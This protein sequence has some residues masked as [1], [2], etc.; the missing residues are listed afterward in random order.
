MR[1]SELHGLSGNCA[2][3]GNCGGRAPAAV[4]AAAAG[5]EPGRG[6]RQGLLHLEPIPPRK[7][8][9][10]KERQRPT[11]LDEG[12]SPFLAPAAAD[13]HQRGPLGMTQLRRPSNENEGMP[14][15]PTLSRRYSEEPPPLPVILGR[16]PSNED[17]AKSAIS[18][19]TPSSTI[20]M[21]RSNGPPTPELA[22]HPFHAWCDAGAG[23][24]AMKE[25][26]ATSTKSPCRAPAARR[27][28]DPAVEASCPKQS[29]GALAQGSACASGRAA[30]G[31]RR[32]REVLFEEGQPH[33]DDAVLA[34]VVLGPESAPSRA[35]HAL[36]TE[37]AAESPPPPPE[38]VMCR[39]TTSDPVALGAISEQT[40]SP[41]AEAPPPVNIAKA[42]RTLSNPECFR[43]NHR[44]SHHDKPRRSAHRHR[45]WHEELASPLSV[46][47]S[48]AAS[49]ETG[50][51][52]SIAHRH[53][54][55]PP[56]S[57]SSGSS[58][59]GDISG[60]HWKRGP[61]IGAGSYG[62]VFTALSEHGKIFAVKQAVLDDNESDRMFRCRLQEE[63][64]ICKTLRHP[65]IVSYLGH[66]YINNAL[67]I[68]LEYVPGGSM[69]SILKEFGPLDDKP[70]RLASRGLLEGL[71]HL[72]S[73]SPP[74]VHRDI[75]GANVLVDLNFR[76][77]LADFGCSKRGDDT[78]SLR[79]VGS[80][81]WMAPEVILQQDGHGRKADV[82]SLGCTIIEMS[83]AQKP[84]G[85][86]AFDN[87]ACALRHIAM[88]DATPPVPEKL[89]ENLMD[90]VAQCTRREPKSRPSARQAVQ[91]EAL[92]GTSPKRARRP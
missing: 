24:T 67:Y 92:E 52:P 34:D 56:A 25:A 73:R 28:V 88:S 62:C 5:A 6:H 35:P 36:R 44:S 68:Y 57:T 61:K 75:K 49:V 81:P 85:D 27:A 17:C 4:S 90:L 58:D 69:A 16:R 31:H 71:V 37:A 79:T 72:H 19:L 38:L 78:K 12:L 30:V 21:R 89:D 46:A 60:Q 3:S 80:V 64:D 20:S 47:C 87:V 26:P 41:T 82:W 32:Q 33:R 8:S 70:L 66:D 59:L 22:P 63:L 18:L 42:S 50:D 14:R 39:R 54:L 29:D 86:G 43:S 84:W 9:G 77:K 76:V 65:N 10:K 40:S 23:L 15:L 11:A 2:L 51:S 48:T 1:P 91:H 13:S 55:T 7:K 83:S 74:V 45:T 53:A